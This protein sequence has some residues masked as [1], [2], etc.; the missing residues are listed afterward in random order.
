MGRRRKGSCNSEKKMIG[1]RTER[2]ELKENRVKREK[3]NMKNQRKLGR[4]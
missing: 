3:R 1:K 4:E 2:R